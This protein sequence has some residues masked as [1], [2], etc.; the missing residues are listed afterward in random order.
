MRFAY[1]RLTVGIVTGIHLAAI[2]AFALLRGG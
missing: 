2:V 1:M